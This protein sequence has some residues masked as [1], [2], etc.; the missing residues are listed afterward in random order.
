V[1]TEDSVEHTAS[2]FCPEDGKINDTW[3]SPLATTRQYGEV[4]Q[5]KRIQIKHYTYCSLTNKCTIY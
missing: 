4:N 2:I 1:G 5:E 3:K